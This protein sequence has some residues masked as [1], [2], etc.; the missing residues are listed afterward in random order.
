M[1]VWG[2]GYQINRQRMILSMSQHIARLPSYNS[3]PISPFM[4]MIIYTFVL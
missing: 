1:T 3:K 4:W 2:D